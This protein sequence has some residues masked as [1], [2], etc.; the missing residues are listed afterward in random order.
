[1]VNERNYRVNLAGNGQYGI[2]A[3]LF[4][5]RSDDL[6][7]NRTNSVEL[8]RQLFDE[9]A[10]S[11]PRQ[12]KQCD[13]NGIRADNTSAFLFAIIAYHVTNKNLEFCAINLSKK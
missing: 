4:S 3:Y 7:D 1:V 6:G 10:T 2:G 9:N 8:H 13:L 11:R 5:I 12:N